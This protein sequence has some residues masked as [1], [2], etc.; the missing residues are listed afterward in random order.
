MTVKPN[1]YIT[2]KRDDKK[3][4]KRGDI[5]QFAQFSFGGTHL[6]EPQQ[7][8]LVN[9]FTA[10]TSCTRVRYYPLADKA[11]VT[12]VGFGEP[13]EKDFIAQVEACAREHYTVKRVTR[14]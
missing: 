3:R 4:P 12:A 1:L 5:M 11:L 2:F 10:L 13:G 14:P 9:R 7:R 8:E 6:T